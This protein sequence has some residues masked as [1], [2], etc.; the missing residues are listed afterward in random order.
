[1]KR[2][3]VR[4]TPLAK[5]QLNELYDYIATHGHPVT[6]LGYIERI[7]SFCRGFETFPERGTIREDIRPGLR[8]VGFERRVTIA[9][10]IEADE[11]QIISILYACIKIPRWRA[12]HHQ[13][14]RLLPHLPLHGL[15][16]PRRAVHAPA[17]GAG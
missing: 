15:R 10:I 8:L 4:F 9:F 1:V 6:A 16:R 3:K 7:E 17:A 11:V 14:R 13:D 5:R 12:D 2:Y